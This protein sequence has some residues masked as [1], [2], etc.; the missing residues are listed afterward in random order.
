MKEEKIEISRLIVLL[1]KQQFPKVGKD[2]YVK[3]RERIHEIDEALAN[4]KYPEEKKELEE[5]KENL[6]DYG[7][8]IYRRRMK[9]LL[10]EL[11]KKVIGG[12]VNILNFTEEEMKIYNQILEIIEDRKKELLEGQVDIL[13]DDYK[14]ISE[15]PE[16]KE[17][18]ED[19]EGAIE[20]ESDEEPEGVEETGEYLEEEPVEY[21]EEEKEEVKTEPE[22]EERTEGTEEKEVNLEMY[23]KN[24]K[25][26]VAIRMIS[27]KPFVGLDG[28][29]YYPEKG[30]VLNL[31]EKVAKILIDG[32]YAERI[33][34][35]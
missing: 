27:P 17:E 1:K 26:T 21:D 12:K 33:D 2:F 16:E 34:V 29:Y 9:S 25:I 23:E 11:S 6:L 5:E 32:G 35:R 22:A 20:S 18:T 14:G 13:N 3:F 7:E 28:H 30:D 31:D 10:I 8:R 24:K 19:E 15:F 4:I